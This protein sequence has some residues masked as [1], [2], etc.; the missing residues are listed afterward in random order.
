VIV[1]FFRRYASRVVQEAHA[2]VTKENAHYLQEAIR[3]DADVDRLTQ[4][5]DRARQRVA[6]VES[7]LDDCDNWLCGAAKDL[8][9]RLKATADA[10]NT[11]QNVLAE[12]DELIARM[13]A[14]LVEV[15]GRLATA[16]ERLAG[17]EH[18]EAIADEDRAK[19]Y[20]DGRG[21]E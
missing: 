9:A 20:Y 14:E 5:R 10:C 8:R 4:E 19:R 11:A 1:D 7:L 17:F 16:E 2:R 12:R 13:D 18:A 15:S 6:V 21:D 3:R